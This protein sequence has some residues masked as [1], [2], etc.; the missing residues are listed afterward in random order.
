MEKGRGGKRRGREG[1]REGKGGEGREGK[2][3]R[4]EGGEGKDKKGKGT[5]GKVSLQFYGTLNLVSFSCLP[6]LI[7]SEPLRCYRNTLLLE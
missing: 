2:K 1:K 6:V 4:K 7:F 5:G 3:R